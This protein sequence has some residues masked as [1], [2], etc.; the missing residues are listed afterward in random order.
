MGHWDM[1]KCLNGVPAE[2]NDIEAMNLVSEADFANSV[3]VNTSAET[4]ETRQAYL[5]VTF[6]GMRLCVV[7]H[8]HIDPD[9]GAFTGPGYC[10]IPGWKGW[11][12]RPSA[13]QC[14][15]IDAAPDTGVFPGD[16]RYPHRVQVS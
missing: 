10:F 15:A 14:T 6:G 11:S 8:I 7:G 12:M 4:R 2:F 1:T 3:Y 16:N 9:T 5:Y 13:A